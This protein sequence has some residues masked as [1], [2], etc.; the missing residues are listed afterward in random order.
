MP[1][2]L[3]LFFCAYVDQLPPLPYTTTTVILLRGT[4][5]A[6]RFPH[7]LP[8][9][10]KHLPP[11]SVVLAAL[12]AVI[13]PLPHLCRV[14]CHYHHHRTTPA[15]CVTLCRPC[16]T[17]LF[18]HLPFSLQ[19]LLPVP[20]TCGREE[21]GSP[22]ALQLPYPKRLYVPTAD[23]LIAG[24]PTGTGVYYVAVDVPLPLPL[25]PTQ[26]R[27]AAFCHYANAYPFGF[28]GWLPLLPFCC[29]HR[30]AAAAALWFLRS[31]CGWLPPP[32]CS[33]VLPLL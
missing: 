5:S 33:C 31:T 8:L 12:P 25:T 30:L 21:Y 17:C 26:P 19:L 23:L 24:F 11:R 29:C 3:R 27:S 2:P 18:Y 15:V 13:A 22:D 16:L 7:R 32:R 20:L 9:G 14:T 10:F 28:L 1:R 6:C 4:I